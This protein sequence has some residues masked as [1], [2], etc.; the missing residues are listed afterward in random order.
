MQYKK[1]DYYYSMMMMMMMPLLIYVYEY[2]DNLFTVY[3]S[4]QRKW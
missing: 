1:K 3:G 4:Y 2:D